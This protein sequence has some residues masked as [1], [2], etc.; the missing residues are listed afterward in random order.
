MNERDRMDAGRIYDPGDPAIL[1]EQTGYGERL[2][3]FN[4]TRPSEQERRA[5]LDEAYEKWLE[6]QE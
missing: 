4:A 1:A 3:D 6:L 2:Y 5:A